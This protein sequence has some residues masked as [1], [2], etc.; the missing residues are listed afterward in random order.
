MKPLCDWSASCDVIEDVA[1]VQNDP[2]ERER[3]RERENERVRDREIEI[4]K[5]YFDS[6]FILANSSLLE[7]RIGSFN[8]EAGSFI[9]DC[10]RRRRKRRRGSSRGRGRRGRK[11]MGEEEAE[12]EKKE[13]KE[14][15]RE[16]EEEEEEEV[17]VFCSLLSS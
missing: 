12:Y 10:R 2:V 4:E 3:E 17:V 16:E 11:A 6:Y 15:E 7:F 13:K 1:G 5:A 8:S 9:L 14:K